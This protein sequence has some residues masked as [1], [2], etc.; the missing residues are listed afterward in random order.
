MQLSDIKDWLVPISSA[1]GVVSVATGAFLA[2]RDFGLKAKA[3]ARLAESSRVEADIKLVQAFNTLLDIAHARGPSILASDKLF[4]A[5]S[6]RFEVLSAEQAKDLAVVTMPVGLASQ[7]AAIAGVAALGERH[8]LLR[9]MA[10]QALRTLSTFKGSVAT[11]LLHR[12]EGR[13]A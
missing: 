2:L 11:E 3:E 12:L 8:A 4:A 10:I 13:D 1:F 7:D 9:P 5:M 6:K